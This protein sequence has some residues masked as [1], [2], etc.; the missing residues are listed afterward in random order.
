MDAVYTCT[1]TEV[2][3]KKTFDLFSTGDASVQ[4]TKTAVTKRRLFLRVFTRLRNPLFWLLFDVWG[5]N[6][7]VCLCTHATQGTAES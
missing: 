2:D 3:Y 4:T 6:E 1:L 7:L 5:D